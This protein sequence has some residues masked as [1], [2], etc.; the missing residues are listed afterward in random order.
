MQ[1]ASVFAGKVNHGETRGRQLLVEPLPGLDI[2]GVDL[3]LHIAAPAAVPIL[4]E[5]GQHGAPQNKGP[6]ADGARFLP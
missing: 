2:A 3:L 5:C 4:R 1:L 6:A